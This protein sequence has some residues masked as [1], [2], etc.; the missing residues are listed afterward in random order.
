MLL[1]E[2]MKALRAPAAGDVLTLPDLNPDLIEIL[3]RPNFSFMRLA[4]IMRLSGMHIAK[5][6][7]CEQAAVIHYLLG[8]YL[9]HGSQWSEKADE[10]LEQ[11]RVA[12]FDAQQGN[13][14]GR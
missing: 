6:S 5:K 14:G 4:Q 3:G 8:L 1:Y 2:A 9:K 10:D 13:G 7:E 11:R 12:V